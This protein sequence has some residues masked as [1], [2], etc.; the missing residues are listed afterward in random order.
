[1]T[2]S[3]EAR[4]EIL[5]FVQSYNLTIN[6]TN[7][8]IASCSNGIVNAS[9]TS[10]SQLLTL[11]QLSELLLNSSFTE[12]DFLVYTVN[13]TEGR[14]VNRSCMQ[15]PDNFQMT[16]IIVLASSGGSALLIICCLGVCMVSCQCVFE[17]KR[18][19][20]RWVCG[21][22]GMVWCVHYKRTVWCALL[23]ITKKLSTKY[24]VYNP[25]VQQPH[26]DM[27][28]T[29]LTQWCFGSCFRRRGQASL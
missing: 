15:G 12:E 16:I 11:C 4:T 8:N 25:F 9:F 23:N 22:K 28:S 27:L 7:P 18:K 24:R 10:F 19:K 26:V 20:H 2:S 21:R 1:M 6:I 5:N 14:P 17:S 29:I 13:S 3:P